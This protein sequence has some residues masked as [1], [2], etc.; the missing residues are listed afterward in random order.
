MIAVTT[1]AEMSCDEPGC[2]K[3]TPVTLI[4]LGTGTFG[5]QARDAGWQVSLPRGPAGQY[6]CRCPKHATEVFAPT[7]AETR[8]VNGGH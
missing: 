5:G 2:E 8:A 7:H 3:R 6:V 4:L 1:P